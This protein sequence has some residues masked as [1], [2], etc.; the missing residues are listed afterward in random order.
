M[1][2]P[3]SRFTVNLAMSWASSVWACLW[4]T[5]LKRSGDVPAVGT[6]QPDDVLVDETSLLCEADKHPALGDQ[7]PEEDP[8][9]CFTRTHGYRGE[10]DGD[11]QDSAVDAEPCDRRRIQHEV[12]GPPRTAEHPY[13]RPVQFDDQ[14]SHA[15]LPA[16]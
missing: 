10:R 3:A 5:D 13:P 15:C 6:Q 1:A 7:F 14:G 11:R 9:P 4:G 16:A 12:E 2:R 8:P